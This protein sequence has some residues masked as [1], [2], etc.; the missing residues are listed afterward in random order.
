MTW[1][2]LGAWYWLK[3]FTALHR[4]IAEQLS[5]TI[6][7][8]LENPKWMTVG[9]TALCL[10]DP[11]KGIAIDNYRPISWKL[12][13]GITSSFW[14]DLLENTDK[15]LN[16]QKGGRKKSRGTKDQLLMNKTVLKVEEGQ[17]CGLNTMR[18]IL[19]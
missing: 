2:W 10:K 12:L 1:T 19:G 8:E 7:S 4:R 18:R 14:Y 16:E 6:N 17:K 11:G 13:T 5:G 15:V 3:N 9:K